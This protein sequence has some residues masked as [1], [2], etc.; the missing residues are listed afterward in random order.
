MKNLG[1][2]CV[3]RGL[4]PEPFENLVILNCYKNDLALF[5]Y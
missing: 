2:I 3:K 5:H 1:F 4:T